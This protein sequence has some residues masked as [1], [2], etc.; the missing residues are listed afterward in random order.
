MAF[1]VPKGFICTLVHAYIIIYILYEKYI[2]GRGKVKRRIKN[3]V[4]NHTEQ[5]VY[6]KAGEEA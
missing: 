4:N 5:K 1:A 6:S 2:P 3:F